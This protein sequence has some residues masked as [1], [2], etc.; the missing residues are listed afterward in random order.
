LRRGGKKK[1]ACIC[2]FMKKLLG[3]EKEESSFLPEGSAE[4]AKKKKKA[5]TEEKEGGK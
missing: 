5:A 3:L 4:L 2:H 1:T